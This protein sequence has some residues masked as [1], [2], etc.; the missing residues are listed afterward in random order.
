MKRA[1]MTRA[2]M[3]TLL[4]LKGWQPARFGTAWVGIYS[5]GVGLLYFRTDRVDPAA[6]NWAPDWTVTEISGGGADILDATWEVITY[7]ILRKLLAWL[8]EN[9]K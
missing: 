3:E 7:D 2:Q 4:N 1:Q 6:P 8:K 5:E 9:G